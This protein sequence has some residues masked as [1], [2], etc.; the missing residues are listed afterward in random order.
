M[1]NYIDFIA[2]KTNY[3]MFTSVLQCSV[4]NRHVNISDAIAEQYKQ[5]KHGTN[6]CANYVKQIFPR[7]VTLK[8]D[9]IMFIR[10]LQC[11]VYSSHVN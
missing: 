8:T 7:H 3:I 9:Y 5:V 1:F 11:S 2:L 6:T 4:Y 10:V